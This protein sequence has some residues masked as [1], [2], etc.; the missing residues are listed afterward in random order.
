MF[1]FLH[2]PKLRDPAPVHL[3][4]AY[5]DHGHLRGAFPAAERIAATTLSLPIGPHTSKDDADRVAASV[6][7][8]CGNG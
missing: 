1:S 5:A 2:H 3:T 6:V 4:E 8:F 7:A